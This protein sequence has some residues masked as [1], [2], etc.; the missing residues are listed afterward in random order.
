VPAAANLTRAL[1]RHLPFV[2]KVPRVRTGGLPIRE[3]QEDITHMAWARP[4]TIQPIYTK[5]APD[6]TRERFVRHELGKRALRIFSE[7]EGLMNDADAELGANL[8]RERPA[9][10]GSSLGGSVRARLRVLNNGHALLTG[11]E[12]S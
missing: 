12:A 2:P 8:P 1:R 11:R 7:L 5:S 6:P 10:V 4:T 9:G 3:F